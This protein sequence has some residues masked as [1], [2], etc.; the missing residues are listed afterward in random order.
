MP[1]KSI[2]RNISP[3]I[4][5]KRINQRFLKMEICMVALLSFA[6]LSVPAFGQVSASISGTITDISQAVLPGAAVTA[7]NVDTGV[8]TRATV[9]NAGVYNFPSLQPGNYTLSADLSGFQKSTRTNVRLGTGSQIRMNFEMAVAGTVTEVE[10]T[11][12]AESMVLEAGSSTGIVLAESTILEMPLLSNDTLDLTRLMGGVITADLGNMGYQ[13]GMSMFAGVFAKDI[14]VSRDG[15]TV[16]EVRYNTGASTASRLNTEMV[17]EFKMVL[18]PVDAELGRGAGQ[19]Q[20]TTKSGSNAFHGSGVWNIQNTALDAWDYLDKNR[21]TLPSRNWRNLNTYTLTASGPIVK[22]K[23]FFFA[24]WDQQISRARQSISASVLSPCARKG[25]YRYLSTVNS[26]GTRVGVRINNAYDDPSAALQGG[27]VSLVL[28]SVDINTGAPLTSYAVPNESRFGEWAGRTVPLQVE[29]VNVLDNSFVWNDSYGANCENYTVPTSGS[30]STGWD[31]YRHTYDRSGFV[32]RF[33]DIMPDANNWEQGDGLNTAVRRWTRTSDGVGLIYG[34]SLYDENRK[35]VTFKI[36]HNINSEH[37]LSGTYSYEKSDGQDAERL[38]DTGYGGIIVRKP[39]TFT[40]SLVS[41]LRPT[42]LNEF[43]AG[44]SRSASVTYD[45]LNNP[46]TGEELR[47]LLLTLLPNS[48]NEPILAGPGYGNVIF[49]PQGSSAGGSHPVGN[50]GALPSMWGGHDPRWTFSDTLTWMRGTHS[51]KGGFEF[52]HAQSWQKFGGPGAMTDNANTYPSIRGGVMSNLSPFRNNAMSTPVN[53]GDPNS[54]AV[55]YPVPADIDYYNM[56]DGSGNYSRMYGLMAYMAG[57]I[58]NFSQYYYVTDPQNPRWNDPTKGENL[59]IADLRQREFSFFFKDDWRIT[60]DL[61]LNLGARYEYYGV[62]WN[63]TGLTNGIKDGLRGMFGAS[64][65]SSLDE[66]MPAVPKQTDYRTQQIFIGPNSRNPDVSAY[67]KDWNNWAP[68]VG[69]SW[70]LPWFGKGKTT[71]RGGY[72]ISYTP[73]ANF[74]H[75]EHQMGY[76]LVLA[77]QPGMSYTHIYNG[78]NGCL[79]GSGCYIDFSRI[80]DVLPLN[81]T[82]TGKGFFGMDIQPQVLAEQPLTR[83]DQILYM[84]DPDIR[85]PYIQS[86]TLAATRNVGGFLTLDVRYIGTLSRK[87]VGRLPV[88]AANYINTGIMDDLIKIR[89]GANDSQLKVLNKYIAPGTLAAGVNSVADQIRSAYGSQLGTGTLMAIAAGN[90]NGGA[91]AVNG[92]L[93]RVNCALGAITAGRCPSYSAGV[94]GQVLREGAKYYAENVAHNATAGDPYGGLTPDTLIYTNPQYGSM[95][96]YSSGTGLLMNRRH[97]NYHSMQAQAT[98]RP[99]RGLSFQATYTWSR[100]LGREQNIGDY[101]DWSADYWLMSMHRS[102][103]FNLNGNFTLPLGAN[104]FFF[105]DTQGAVKKAIEGWDIGWIMR[106]ES[107]PPM[108]LSGANTLWNHGSLNLV[109]PDLWDNK[110]GKYEKPDGE[111]NGYYYGTRYVRVPDPQ[112]NPA[113]GYVTGDPAV[114]TSVAG[115]C[116]T[117]LRALADTQTLDAAGNPTIVFQN[118]LPGERGNFQPTSLTGIGRWTL[119]MNFAKRIDFM[120]GK[121][122]ELRIDAQNVANHAMPSQGGSQN[123]ARSYSPGNPSVTV[124]T[125]STTPFGQVNNKVGHRTFQAKIRLAF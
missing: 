80:N 15:I 105:R 79:G 101:R 116:A 6:L 10:V 22:N 19:L 13:D 119:D 31:D 91:T 27:V 117:S 85:S 78:H 88:N 100:N 55:R 42:L 49:H 12:S 20:M 98:M 3:P 64:G 33:T 7:L 86:L 70:Q 87:M 8:E 18:S 99:T 111:I 107:G 50:R 1:P 110:A 102:H 61:T 35:A 45:P 76:S 44:M 34:G 125:A 115:R 65:I 112:C 25:I 43:R 26:A 36:D 89:A 123:G 97:S 90:S 118:A 92:G 47:T 63:D 93:A 95:N 4:K 14:N 46:A 2:P 60:R 94:L 16:S 124:N 74:D 59:Y 41:T 71:L 68:H 29:Y 48:I 109:R 11:S 82:Q 37:R 9:N 121:S 58:A 28:P 73:I 103:Q 57:S 122:I 23:T 24:S 53:P 67:N 106:I 69:F 108:S 75:M 40:A 32:K 52:R 72:S 39:Q 83:R 62:P 38:W 84:F 81:D 21:G 66:W 114:A 51:F 56:T 120:E 96:A 54:K 104:G 113:N 5:N 77:M 17:G 30:A